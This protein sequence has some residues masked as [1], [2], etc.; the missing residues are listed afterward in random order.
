MQ[1][2]Q[3]E[4]KC[5][6]NT[7]RGLGKFLEIILLVLLTEGQITGIKGTDLTII[8]RSAK[9]FTSEG[10]LGGPVGCEDYVELEVVHRRERQ[11]IILYRAQTEF[12]KQQ[13]VDRTNLFDYDITLIALERK[14]VVLRIGN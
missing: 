13:G 4:K 6:C 11:Q 3:S 8:V 10:C 5:M 1:A 7:R 2:I 12:Q 14:Q 9:D